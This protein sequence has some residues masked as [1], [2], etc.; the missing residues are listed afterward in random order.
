MNKSKI[1]VVKNIKLKVLICLIIVLIIIIIC[2]CG[3]K[4]E[5]NNIVTITSVIDIKELDKNEDYVETSVPV[6]EQ[7]TKEIIN[8]K[9]YENMP[10]KIDEYK[11]VGQITIPKLNI[12]KYIL[13]ET[14]KQS[15]KK[16]VTKICGPEVNKPGNFCIAG[17][18]YSN[19]FGKINLLEI[20]DEIQ[21][22]DTYDRVL[23]YQVYSKEKVSPNDTNCLAQNTYNEREI[24]LI[25]CTV[26]AIKR[27]VIKA[28]EIYD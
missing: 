20:G 13:G 10:E 6:G 28:I 15:L 9:E 23:K 18:N 27:V 1:Y 4:E 11:V 17:H 7:D 5:E 22:K 16:G 14:T 24:T 12:E 25:T 19:T 3:R 2:I 8:L 21:I 26:G